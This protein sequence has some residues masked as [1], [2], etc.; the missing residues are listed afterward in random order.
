MNLMKL[1]FLGQERQVQHCEEGS[2][3][4]SMQLGQARRIRGGKRGKANAEMSSE[5][6]GW[7]ANTQ[8]LEETCASFRTRAHERLSR[9]FPLFLA[10]TSISLAGIGE[11]NMTKYNEQRTTH[12]SIS[13]DQVANLSTVPTCPSLSF[14]AQLWSRRFLA[15]LAPSAVLSLCLQHSWC[16]SSARAPMGWYPTQKTDQEQNKPN[17]Q[18]LRAH[19]C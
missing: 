5:L 2:H 19:S 18:T 9:H 3:G 12:V 11:T 8:N 16:V 7:P 17:K 6:V 1:M 13:K 10:P 15:P 14:L 4:G